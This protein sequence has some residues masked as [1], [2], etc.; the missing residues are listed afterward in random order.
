[1][2]HISHQW[3]VD[4]SVERST[5]EPLLPEAQIPIKVNDCFWYFH[6]L[7]GVL[8]KVTPTAINIK[9]IS[10]SSRSEFEL[11]QRPLELT[12]TSV[13]SIIHYYRLF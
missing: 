8:G 2:V 7:G 5:Y 10:C 6:F 1:M 9:F 13:L 12:L 4:D 3:R 11:H